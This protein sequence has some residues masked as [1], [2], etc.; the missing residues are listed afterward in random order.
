M[1]IP[2]PNPR[3]YRHYILLILFIFACSTTS[4]AAGS[5]GKH[6][7]TSSIQ[8]SIT[9]VGPSSGPD[10]GGTTVTITGTGFVRSAAVAF[11]GS[12]ATAVTFVSSTKLQAITPAHTSGTVSVAVTES[13]H[14]QTATLSNSFTY[15]STTTGISV[16]S[17]SPAQGPTTGGTVVKIT[18]KGFQTGAHV[19]FGSSQSTAVTVASS[20]EID[21]MSPPESS[22]TVTLTVTDPDTQSSSLPS[23]FTYTS[24][25]SV[26]SI[27]P[28]SG[29]VTGGTTVTILGSGFQSGA[30][31]TFGGIAATSVN[32]V[33]STQIQAVSPGSPAGTVSITVTNSDS[34]SG[35]LAS[36]FTFFHTVA[37][38]WAGS[39]STVSGYNVYRSSTSGGPYNRI[40]SALLPGTAF[41]DNNVQAGQTYFYVTTAV[42]SSNVESGYSNQAQAVVPSP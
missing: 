22:G 11:G 34:Q 39:S 19:A 23:A 29:P 25:P 13:P 12:A 24:G 33:S 2:G 3:G 7:G 27:S 28:Y 41:T 9:G 17:A 40:N 15:G 18:G 36:A 38:A 16:S 1:R 42:N 31:V 37:L 4:F 10:T 14:N 35:T 20:T 8:V 26:T 32:L 5:N 21:A 6:W 30:T